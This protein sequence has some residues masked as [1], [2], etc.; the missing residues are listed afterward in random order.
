MKLR[1]LV[2]AFAMTAPGCG[3]KVPPQIVLIRK[4]WQIQKDLLKQLQTVRDEATMKAAEPAIT[5]LFRDFYG[6]MNQVSN[7]L[8]PSPSAEAKIR[9]EAAELERNR[10]SLGREL[11]RVKALPGGTELIERINK[12]QVAP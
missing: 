7:M 3:E 10:I 5:E 12:V 4:Q 9:E 2:L 11:D 8:P 1:Y 6:T